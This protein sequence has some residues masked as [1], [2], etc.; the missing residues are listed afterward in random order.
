MD[1]RTA[2]AWPQDRSASDQPFQKKNHLAFLGRVESLDQD[3]GKSQDEK[4]AVL[5]ADSLTAAGVLENITK[6]LS[7][8]AKRVLVN[9][10][11]KDEAALLRLTREDLRMVWS[12]GKKTISEIEALQSKLRPKNEQALIKVQRNTSDGKSMCKLSHFQIIDWGII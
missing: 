9:L 10:G 2:N 3:M 11:V 7:V 12:C 5:S 8:R 4:I 1:Y 6:A